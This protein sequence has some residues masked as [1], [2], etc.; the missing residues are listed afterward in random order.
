[1]PIKLIYGAIVLLIVGVLPMPY[2]Y[3]TFLRIIITII[4]IW[5]SVVAFDRDLATSK[6]IYVGIA[7]LFN[8][9][10]PIHLTK[11]I[12]IVIDIITALILFGT[13]NT[14]QENTDRIN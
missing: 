12:W 11:D 7:I 4:F 3:Y 1:M 5:S 2:G 8:P 9:I 6:W 10:I 14:I 13:K